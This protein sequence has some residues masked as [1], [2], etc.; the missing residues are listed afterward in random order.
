MNHI[1]ERPSLLA[2]TEILYILAPYWV[3]ALKRISALE[4]CRSSCDIT[5]YKDRK[6]ATKKSSQRVT[7][8]RSPVYI[9]SMGKTIDPF[10]H[11]LPSPFSQKPENARNCQSQSLFGSSL[12][13]S[14]IRG[15]QFCPIIPWHGVEWC[16]GG[17]SSSSCHSSIRFQM[18]THKNHFCIAADEFTNL[19]LTFTTWLSD[20]VLAEIGEFQSCA[21]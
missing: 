14:I 9:A 7:T 13:W 15:F 17:V 1:H 3:C 19:L 5:V 11:I 2:N 21:N 6:K 8:H 12:I 20:F 10:Y 4:N 16:G 18:R